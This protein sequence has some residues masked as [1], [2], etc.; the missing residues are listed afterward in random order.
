MSV[1]PDTS[2]QG[3]IYVDTMVL[4]VFLRAE[5]RVRP[6][7]RNFFER[8]GIGSI[9]AYTATPQLLQPRQY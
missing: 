4:Y 9:I 2:H 5:E 1:P 6:I 7:L 8:V 3:E